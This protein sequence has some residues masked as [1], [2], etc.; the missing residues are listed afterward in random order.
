MLF[1]D[2]AAY[3][4]GTEAQVHKAAGRLLKHF[5]QFSLLMHVGSLD[6]DGNN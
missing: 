2:D 6:A 5:Q 4:Y 3:L 1:V